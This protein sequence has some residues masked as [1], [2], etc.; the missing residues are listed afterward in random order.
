[1]NIFEAMYNRITLKKQLEVEPLSVVDTKTTEFTTGNGIADG[2]INQ[3]FGFSNND[4]RTLTEKELIKKWR[5]MSNFDIVNDAIN[6]IVNDAVIIDNDKIVKID[7]SEIELSDKIKDKLKLEFEGIL[8]LLNFRKNAKR[9]FRNYYIDGRI[10]KEIVY[11]KNNLKKGIIKINEIDPLFIEKIISIDKK[12]MVY[13]Y[14]NPDNN[15][16]YEIP[17]DLVCFTGSNLF[18]K[19]M[20]NSYKNLEI[21]Y[22]NKA[23][24]SV[25]NLRLIEDMIVIYR[26]IRSS[27]KRI[28]NVDTGYLN[29]TKAEQY[30][31]KLMHKFKNKLSYDQNTGSLNNQKNVVSMIEDMYFAKGADGKGTSV[32]MLSGGQSLGEMDDVY[33]FLRK[34]WRHLLMPEGRLN[35]EEK[36][37]FRVE[38]YSE[39]EK[40][41][42]NFFKHIQTVRSD[43]SEQFTQ[44]LKIQAIRKNIMKESDF[45][46]IESSL[47]Y[48]WTN[49][50]HYTE[51]MESEVMKMRLENVGTMMEY[52]GQFFTKE[53]IALKGL[54]YTEEEWKEKVKELKKEEASGEGI[55]P[56]EDDDDGYSD[57]PE[58][59]TKKEPKEKPEEEVEKEDE[60]DKDKKEEK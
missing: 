44:L 1:M 34:A 21:S 22:L 58:P 10:V 6:E 26:I 55:E 51:I 18:I 56:E 13:K 52:A 32:D 41:E 45:D 53:D 29:K 19:D 50:N 15:K 11:D 60:E 4:R 39:I 46:I 33:Y 12:E 54:K 5:M 43:Y 16:I 36:S 30:L 24:K 59:P 49:E 31:N 42:V 3:A 20:T 38:Q 25:N 48:L 40:E 27:E 17:L 23:E 7:L 8:K 14:T 37:Q 35:L 57:K 2:G 28:F 47:K 9:D